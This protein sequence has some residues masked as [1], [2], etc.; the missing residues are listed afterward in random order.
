MSSDDQQSAIAANADVMNELTG[1]TISVVT[2][3]AASRACA[4]AVTDMVVLML[5]GA[6]LRPVG[7]GCT[8]SQVSR[9]PAQTS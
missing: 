3:G 1:A 4:A 9:Q 8:P 2:P 6:N 5:N 7:R